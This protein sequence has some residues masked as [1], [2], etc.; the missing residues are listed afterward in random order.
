MG[1]VC[2][3]DC[4]GWPVSLWVHITRLSLPR[5]FS[6]FS[7]TLHATAPPIC[8]NLLQWPLSACNPFITFN[9][10][11]LQVGLLKGVLQRGSAVLPRSATRTR[12]LWPIHQ[13]SARALDSMTS[14]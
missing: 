2:G 13:L 7:R 6:D 9:L 11:A 5:W 4:S 12:I 1:L 10:R 14:I 8:H 3:E